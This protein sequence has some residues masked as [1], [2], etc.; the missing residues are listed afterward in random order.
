MNGEASWWMKG[1]SPCQLEVYGVH[2]AILIIGCLAMDLDFRP[3]PKKF[4]VLFLLQPI[5][6]LLK[7]EIKK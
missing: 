5:V 3:F 1:D 6:S 7:I 4:T 2:N